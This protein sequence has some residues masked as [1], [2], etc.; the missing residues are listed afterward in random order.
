[1]VGL[2]ATMVVLWVLWQ[3]FRPKQIAEFWVT[4]FVAQVSWHFEVATLGVDFWAVRSTRAGA[5]RGQRGEAGG[6]PSCWWSGGC[7]T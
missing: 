7:G 5:L 2:A 3:C 1:M 6:V 4:M